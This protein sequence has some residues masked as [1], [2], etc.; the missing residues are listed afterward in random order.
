MKGQKLDNQ[1]AGK[2]VSLLIFFLYC[3]HGCPASALPLPW[4]CPC[5]T[6]STHSCFQWD[7]NK[8]QRCCL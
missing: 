5:P 3:A 2:I 6:P 1:L 4:L 8:L 7:G